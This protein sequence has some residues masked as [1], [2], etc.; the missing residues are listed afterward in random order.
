MLSLVLVGVILVGAASTA[1]AQERQLGAKVGPSFSILEFDPSVGDEYDR[2]TA[3][4]GGG[5]IVL[6]MS[7]RF[8]LQIEALINPKGAKLRLP[9]EPGVTRTVML[10]YVDFPV[11]LRVQGPHSRSLSFHAFGGPYSG[12]RISAK[13][14]ISTIAQ[15]ITSGATEDMSSEVKRFEAGLTGGAGVDIGQRLTIDGRYTRG[16]TGV[17]TEQPDGIQIRTRGLSM[18]VG[19]RF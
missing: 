13:R 6:P 5:F 3:A 11:L 4:G 2:R 17:N 15:S 19:V 8:A 18:M 16:L 1:I 14:E 12:I 9:E 10:R 7:G